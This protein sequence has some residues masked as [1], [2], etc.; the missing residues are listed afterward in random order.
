MILLLILL[1]STATFAGSSKVD[2][3]KSSFQ[4]KANGEITELNSQY[5]SKLTQML[6]SAKKFNKID[7]ILAIEHELSMLNKDK[8]YL[9]YKTPNDISQFEG[10]Y[11]VD[12]PS[13]QRI[14]T[15]SE[16]GLVVST[17]AISPN[18][19][20]HPEW[21]GKWQLTLDDETNEYCYKFGNI[22][23]EFSMNGRR[24]VINVYNADSYPS[25]SRGQFKGSR[26]RI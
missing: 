4:K 21:D 16:T 2:K 26:Q 14:F 13:A 11:R 8:S 19:D 9:L 20:K 17:N 18:G 7:D 15:I 6:Y 10:T 5:E 1:I 24:L 23:W 3:L 25:K 12:E 22:V